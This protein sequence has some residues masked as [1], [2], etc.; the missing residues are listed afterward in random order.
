MLEN[1][2]NDI[3][4]LLISIETAAIMAEQGVLSADGGQAS[5]EIR[6]LIPVRFRSTSLEVNKEPSEAEKLRSALAAAVE[7]IQDYLAYTHDGD[8]WKEDSRAM[9]EMDINDYGR[10]GRLQYALDIL[11]STANQEEQVE[12]RAHIER[13]V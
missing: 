3:R 8:P 10:D 13:N 6:S 2:E 12:R 1:L 4:D 7:T 9:G 5:V 11:A